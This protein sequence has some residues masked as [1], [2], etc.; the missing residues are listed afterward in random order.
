MRAL[1]S[2]SH[3]LRAIVHWQSTLVTV[4]VLLAGVPIGILVG[5]KVVDLLTDALGIVPGADV[6][7]L[8]ITVVVVVALALANLLALLPARFA[9]RTRIFELMRDR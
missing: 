4:V 8:L 3:Q 2:D 7:P 6:S 5:R 1:G 9:A